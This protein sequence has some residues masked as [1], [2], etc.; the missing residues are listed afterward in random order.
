[1]LGGLSG[2]LRSRR[3]GRRGWGLLGS[4]RFRVLWDVVRSRFWCACFCWLVGIG[5]PQDCCEVC[6]M[7][8]IFA[9]L[10]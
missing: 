7:D 1:M 5:L 8:D 2:F 3:R 10:S 9:V 4:W 6:M